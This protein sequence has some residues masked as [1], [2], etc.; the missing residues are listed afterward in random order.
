[1]TFLGS[2]SGLTTEEF[3]S[4]TF[5]DWLNISNLTCCLS[6]RV[7]PLVGVGA[8]LP[9]EMEG[10]RVTGAAGGN[11]DVF[12]S[13]NKFW[14]IVWIGPAITSSGITTSPEMLCSSSFSSFLDLRSITPLLPLA[15]TSELG[16]KLLEELLL[17][18]RRF[19]VS[20]LKDG[21][22]SRCLRPTD[23]LEPF[24]STLSKLFDGHSR[25]STETIDLMGVLGGTGVVWASV[26][27]QETVM[28]LVLLTPEPRLGSM[29][30]INLFFRSWTVPR[31]ESS[32]DSRALCFRLR[33]S[34]RFWY[35]KLGEGDEL[36]RTRTDSL[37]R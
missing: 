25:C 3:K 6:F 1:M 29:Q 18:E 36:V 15:G 20:T 35:V 5:V 24:T 28:L 11:T 13:W 33:F 21:R 19:S 17:L 23:C 8:L 10:F 4:I 9:D 16:I 22:E 34:F 26:A 14:N 30:A 32:S 2:G 7:L 31:T 37:L 12:P 27:L